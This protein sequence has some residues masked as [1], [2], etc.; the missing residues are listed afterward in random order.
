MLFFS[1]TNKIPTEY[2]DK[3]LLDEIESNF[4]IKELYLDKNNLNYLTVLQK[5]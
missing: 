4:T 3:T 2:I 1:L 5:K